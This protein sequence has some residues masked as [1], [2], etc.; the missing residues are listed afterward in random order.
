[1]VYPRGTGAEQAAEKRLFY[2]LRFSS[3][4]FALALCSRGTALTKSS[5]GYAHAF[6]RSV[7]F[8]FSS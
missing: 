7:L 1:M 5:P 4:G 2:A 6:G 3:E 8:I